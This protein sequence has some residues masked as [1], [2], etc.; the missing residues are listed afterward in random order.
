VDFWQVI[1]PPGSPRADVTQWLPLNSWT[2]YQ[3]NCAVCHTSQLRNIKGGGFAPQGPEFREP[4]INCEMCHGPSL[5]HVEAMRKGEPYP[6]APMDPP[7][8]F[9]KLDARQ[10]VAICS[11][12]HMQSALRN[13]GPQGELNYSPNGEFFMHHQSQTYNV[14]SRKAFY[15]DGRFRETTFFVESL[16][17]TRCF[18]EGHATCG[19]CH[20]PHPANAAANPNSLKFLDHPD[21]ICLQCHAEYRQGSA[22][23]RHTHH[24]YPSPG[25][26]CVSCHMPPMVDALLFEARSHEFDQIP[27][28]Q[29]TLTFGEQESPNACQ[30]CH[31]QKSAKW[32]QQALAVWKGP[33]KSH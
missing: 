8:D 13:P 15:K 26:R 3:A 22:F 5:R 33:I 17:R 25:S 31:Q 19:S 20:D 28:A 32:V 12:C 24:S 7:V 11:Q 2:S 21:Q 30:I 29:M 18:R 16:L 10:F 14:F 6:K 27:D 1:D 4:G 9:T 23:V